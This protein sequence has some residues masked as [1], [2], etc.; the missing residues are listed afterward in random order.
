MTCGRR[1][2][3]KRLARRTAH[4]LRRHV[5]EPRRD[6][7]RAAGRAVA[8]RRVHGTRVPR[9]EVEHILDAAAGRRRQ[10]SARRSRAST[11]D[12]PT[13]SSAGFA[14]AAEVMARIEAARHD[15]LGLRHPRGAAARARAGA[16]HRRRSRRGARALGARPS[17]SGA[18]TRSRTRSM[19]Q[20]LALQTLRRDRRAARLRR[21]RTARILADAALLHDV[22]YHINYDQPSQAFV[23]PDPARRSAGHDARRADHDRQRGALPPRRAAQAA[24]TRTS[25]SSTASRAA[26]SS[27]CAAI[28]RVADGFDRGHI[29]AVCAV[30]VRWTERAVRITRG[31]GRPGARAAA[32]AVGREP[33]I[34]ICS[35]RSAA[36]RGD[37]RA[38]RC[39]HHVGL[40]RLTSDLCSGVLRR[41][42]FAPAAGHCW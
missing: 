10:T 38:G 18:I 37:R 17:P 2:R 7:P 24:S 34:A 28:L 15:G 42:L 23:P 12:A 40:K 27:D 14:V 13:S 5:H 20:K 32:R 4:R 31:R 35:R 6:V 33:Q 22:G 41:F 16:H 19:S 9:E 1:S 36:A 30:K 25:A 8:R 26:G 11:P 21:P 29:G 39:R 3:V